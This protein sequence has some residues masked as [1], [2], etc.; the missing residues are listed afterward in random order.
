MKRS[1]CYKYVMAAMAALMLTGLG[2]CVQEDFGLRGDSG[3]RDGIALLIKL[4]EQTRVN[5]MSRALASDF[6]VVNDLNIFV[7]DEGGEIK[8]RLYLDV[9]ALT[10][11]QKNTIDAD[12]TVTPKEDDNGYVEYTIDFSSSYWSGVSIDKSTFYAVANWGGAMKEVV[13][14]M[15]DEGK[16]ATAALNT[17]GELKGLKVR[18]LKSEG[19]VHSSVPTPN[20]MYGEETSDRG[21]IVDPDDPSKKIKVVTVEMKRTAA[22]ITLAM[23]G[24]GLDNN[25]E[26]SVDSVVLRNVPMSCTLGP[27]NCPTSHDGISEYG[28]MKGGVVFSSAKLI[29]TTRKNSDVYKSDSQFQTTIG[30]H[31]TDTNTEDD[32]SDVSGTFVQPLFLFENKQPDGT[33][34]GDNNGNDQA[35]KRPSNCVINNDDYDGSIADYNKTGVCSYIEVYAKY[36]QYK[37]TSADVSQ[38]GTAVWRFFLG[39]NVT[40]NFKVERNTNYRITLKLNN[41]GIGERNYSWRVDASLKEA[42]VVGNENMVVGGGGEMFC[43]EFTNNDANSNMKVKYEGDNNFVY[44]FIKLK[45]NAKDEKECDW[46]PINDGKDFNNSVFWWLTGSEKQLW[47]YVSPLMPGDDWEGD[48]RNCKMT[49]SHPSG[50]PTY[51]TVTFTQ[52]RPV[53]F[54]VTQDDWSNHNSDP[55]LKRAMKLIETHYNHVFNDNGSFNPF[56]FWA[57]RID[58]DAMPWGFP[59]NNQTDGI[60]ITHNQNTGFRNVYHLIEKPETTESSC[61]AHY[62]EASHYLPT[63]K[64]YKK[65][66]NNSDAYVDYQDGSC[67]I[68]AAMQNHFQQYYPYPG[69]PRGDNTTAPMVYPSNMLTLGI[70]NV[71][72][73]ESAS[74]DIKDDRRFSWCVPSVV[75][76]QLVELLD[77]YYKRIDDKTRGFDSKYPIKPWVS[78][79]TSNAATADMASDYPTELG[80]NGMK[81]SFVY[82]FDMDLESKEY[83]FGESGNQSG[84]KYPAYLIVPRKNAVTYRLLNIRP[85]DDGSGSTTN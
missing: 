62:N 35:H 41:T 49:F 64:G 83:Q 15:T 39:S 58:R 3:S 63:G 9:S 48:T 78:Y 69:G 1:A 6:D 70:N 21:E 33:F 38:K 55:D 43:V 68:H 31:Y 2:S 34:G 75:G 46:E 72:R 71:L 42:Q 50:N 47:F 26:I 44:A 23:D 24:T 22:M 13:D 7:G 61:M 11:G 40:N 59:G 65:D 74:N 57:D 66:L 85:D 73:P 25:I 82:Q 29:G 36:T 53:T 37:G 16:P 10:L 79:W 54:S 5:P 51:G 20:V 27:G 32:F 28:D 19:N 80:I 14:V 77:R 67:M 45:G 81:R 84:E 18:E 8:K 12:V 17:I 4:P 76:Y 56:T 52:Y 30:G 60:T